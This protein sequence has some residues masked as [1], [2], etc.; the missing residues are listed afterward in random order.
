MKFFSRF[1][2]FFHTKKGKP[3]K[4]LLY[5][6][7]GFSV[8]AVTILV[9]LHLLLRSGDFTQTLVTKVKPFLVPLGVEDLQVESF[10]LDAFHLLSIDN[11]KLRWRD[12][13]M[14]LLKLSLGQVH[15]R[16][17]LDEIF[18]NQLTVSQ[19]AVKDISLKGNLNLTDTTKEE[20]KNTAPMSYSDIETLL[21]SPP[22]NIDAQN[23]DIQNIV[24]NLAL[25][26][27]D[28][29]SKINHR[30][31]QLHA[32]VIF[33]QN[34]FSGHYLLDIKNDDALVTAAL[35]IDGAITT[36]SVNPGIQLSGRWGVSN[37]NA[38]WSLSE[39]KSKNEIFLKDITIVDNN[40]NNNDKIISGENIHLSYVSSF[41]PSHK[42]AS[43]IEAL[44]P[45]SMDSR[46]K[47]MLNNLK[48]HTY[49]LD[50]T[51]LSLKLSNA[52]E[53][54]SLLNLDQAFMPVEQYLFNLKQRLA[55]DDVAYITQ[56]EI[57]KL[58]KLK[59]NVDALL[60][61]KRD[62]TS[63]DASLKGHVNF[64]STPVS[65]VF[66]DKEKKLKTQLKLSPDFDIKASVKTTV[67]NDFDADISQLLSASRFNIKPR[68]KINNLSLKE[69][70]K[71][72]L[73]LDK[74][75]A[76]ISL[77]SDKSNIKTN[78]N[79]QLDAVQLQG[80]N[81]P[82]SQTTSININ[83]DIALKALN[84]EMDAK[85]N[86]QPLFE[87]SLSVNN[88]PKTAQSHYQMTL[89]MPNSLRQI[90]PEMEEVYALGTFQTTINGDVNLL[91]E[92]GSLLN[93]DFT[94]PE[95]LQIRS[96]GK[97][98]LKPQTVP[99]NPV[100]AFKGPLTIGY[101]IE[102]NKDYALALIVDSQGIK[103]EPLLDYLPFNFSTKTRLDWP[104]SRMTTSGN[105]KVEN[106]NWFDY[107]IKLTNGIRKLKSI[108]AFNFQ[109]KPGWKHYLDDFG[110]LAEIG[111][112]VARVNYDLTLNH[113]KKTVLELD[114][115]HYEKYR[116]KLGIDTELEQK[117]AP[118]HALLYIKQPILTSSLLDWK[119]DEAKFKLDYKLPDVELPQTAKLALSG[120]MNLVANDGI[121]P[122]GVQ[123]DQHLNQS[124][125][126]LKDV[127]SEGYL[128]VGKMVTPL[129]MSF[130]V[131][132]LNTEKLNLHELVLD[133]GQ[134]I[135]NLNAKGNATIDGNNVDMESLF[136]FSPITNM[137]AGNKISGAGRLSL[138][139]RLAM[140]NGDQVSLSGKMNFEKFDFG[141][142]TLKV[143]GING[144]L[145][146]EEELKVNGDQFSYSYLKQ[147]DPFQRVDFGRIQPFVNTPSIT[148][149]QILVDDLTAGPMLANMALNQNLFRLQQF[150]VDLFNGK[151][152]G[153]FYLDTTPGAWK[154]GVLSRMTG[155][156][157]REM[158]KNNPY[159]QDTA[160]SPVNMRMAFEFNVHKKLVEGQIDIS[161]IKRDQLLQLLEVVDPDHVDTQIASLRSALGLAHPKQVKIEMQQGLMNIQVAI[162]TLPAP[163]KITG[164][165]LSAML[166]QFS[167]DILEVEKQ[168]PVQ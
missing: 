87:T 47:L 15:I 66:N 90:M 34:A 8:L 109:A 24:L 97:I 93:V 20:P 105:L 14:G 50:D 129:D 43:S 39:L 167:E 16:Y 23:I 130:N 127:L 128:D 155:V 52:L 126:A 144:G 111:D 63:T 96:K 44:F 98:K 95:L 110:E 136:V 53:M 6:L 2:S 62:K 69:N 168:F 103:A 135:I 141:F 89:N 22:L 75:D 70:S 76:H 119:Q 57:V 164:I 138:P 92:Q 12:H 41:T 10:K 137:V 100:L 140:L 85:I 1:K 83:S 102:Q 42:T 123:L 116:L 32:E 101:N 56:S 86:Q 147:T 40:G 159:I 121:A 114:P 124:R 45:L 33:N 7:G 51:H 3:L 74:T 131:S 104:L 79:L 91:H 146:F 21:Q 58:N 143:D 153:Q 5:G 107:K 117:H 64:K 9:T 151:V 60:S 162:N 139:L 163:I 71:M 94:R 148:I 72:L 156:D 150:D 19:L 134:G 54:D 142:D 48:L 113:D 11:L 31:N 4:W 81:K 106:E 133:A 154:I 157:L 49:R 36:L 82:F 120:K 29:T 26:Q 17:S 161:K 152:A 25:S 132:G 80:L 125:L 59:S 145:A 68:V 67:N 160:Y 115:Q 118:K 13:E 46:L 73:G 37:A 122:T 27:G 158:F 166:Q 108:G 28:I 61:G 35:P 55:V 65:Y 77:F 30:L 149:E 78:V 99:K 84:L 112:V 165:P 18:N 38:Q 88:L